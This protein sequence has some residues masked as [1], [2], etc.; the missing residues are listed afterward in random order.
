MGDKIREG[1]EGMP[2]D[3]YDLMK[4]IED[5]TVQEE[6]VDVDITILSRTSDKVLAIQELRENELKGY[7]ILSFFPCSAGR[8]N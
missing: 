1:C 3:V 8:Q 6:E 7:S 4:K 5:L 2:V